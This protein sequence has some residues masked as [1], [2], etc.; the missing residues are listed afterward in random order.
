MDKIDKMF[1]DLTG[2]IEGGGTPQKKN[3]VMILLDASGSMTSMQ[4]E[5]I[6]A[7]NQQVNVIRESSKDMKTFV[8]FRTFS[9]TPHRPVFWNKSVDILRKLDRDEYMPEGMTAMLDCVGDTL[10]EMKDITEKEA[11]ND[12]SFLVIIISDGAENNSKKYTYG[13][14]QKTI[15]SLTETKKWT[16]TYLGAN[17]DLSKISKD[18]NIPL[19]NTANFVAD[20]IGVQYANVQTMSAYKSYFASRGVGET[21]SSN[22]YDPKEAVIGKIDTKTWKKGKKREKKIAP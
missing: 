15:S 3:Y 21:M 12:T 5:A 14:I 8:T 9:T 4:N 22:F 6:D 13:D 2:D 17:Q 11:K 20:A 7:F 1:D 19:S 16:F 18:L 10:S